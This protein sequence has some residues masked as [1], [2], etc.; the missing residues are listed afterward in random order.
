MAKMA[1]CMAVAWVLCA[2]A[3]CANLSEVGRFGAESSQ[4]AGSTRLAERY[5]GSY[6]RSQHY[7]LGADAQR[8]Q[9]AL[10]ETKR[11]ARDTLL[12]VH[13]VAARYLAT[14]AELAGDDTFRLGAQVRA[15]GTGLAAAPDL[16]LSQPFVSAA[17]ALA[18][19]LSDAALGARQRR[20]VRDFLARN[21]DHGQAVLDGLASVAQ[22]MKASLDNERRDVLGFFETGALG[23]EA[24]G[25]AT[26][27]Y[28]ARLARGL[29][30]DK[31]A[32]YDAADAAAA[33]AT[34]GL[35]AAAAG[36]R[37]LLDNLDRLSARDVRD[38]I[39][40]YRVAVRQGR[41]AL[42]AP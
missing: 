11:A 8:R 41:A 19:A 20:A 5:L 39:D 15:V 28:L 32:E 33:G 23:L 18:G 7:F 30:A 38:R 40:A 12:A 27:P 4:L 3:G 24:A 34:A 21:G 1:R 35:A 14:L 26:G 13:A 9:Q 6:E 29:G 42:A 16:G 31:A 37:L 17:S 22:D 10:D 25:G 2:L 36:H